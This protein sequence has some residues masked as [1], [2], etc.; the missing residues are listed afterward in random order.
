MD[1]W[2]ASGYFLLGAG[3]GALT[4]ALLQAR[5]IRKLKEL[6]EAADHDNPKTKEQ[7]PKSDG[8]KSA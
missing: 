3:V 1:S 4:T 2:M 8:R 6:L 5:Q 7:I